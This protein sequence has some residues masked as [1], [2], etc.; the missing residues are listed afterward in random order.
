MISKS[1]ERLSY[2][3]AGDV[4]IHLFP[5]YVG[6]ED[7]EQA[8]DT[9]DDLVRIIRERLMR[10]QRSRK[11]RAEDRKARAAFAKTPRSRRAKGHEGHE[12]PAVV[13]RRTTKPLP[14]PVL[15]AGTGP[16]A[17]GS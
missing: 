14:C 2:S 1:I 10:E 11:L 6:D 9:Y 15:Q 13:G 4:F 3:I 8:Q 16:R 7:G 5:E 12:G 17:G